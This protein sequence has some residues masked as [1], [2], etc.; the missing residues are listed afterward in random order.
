MLET[1]ARTDYRTLVKIYDG[2]D[3]DTMR[4]ALRRKQQRA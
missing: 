1:P 3:L 2:V 4:E